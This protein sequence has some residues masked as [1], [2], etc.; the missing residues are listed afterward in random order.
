MQEQEKLLTSLRKELHVDMSQHAVSR[1]PYEM[2][3][4]QL[5]MQHGSLPTHAKEQRVT[6]G[7]YAA[8]MPQLSI[9]YHACAFCKLADTEHVLSLLIQCA[10]ACIVMC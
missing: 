2:L 7:L 8:C 6:P 3:F 10:C 4:C 5:P 9:P 1:M